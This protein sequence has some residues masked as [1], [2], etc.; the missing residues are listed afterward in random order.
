MQLKAGSLA[1]LT[2]KKGTVL[3]LQRYLGMGQTFACVMGAPLVW[4][5]SIT[6]SYA[7]RL[8]DTLLSTFTL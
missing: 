1:R 5:T 2:K 6:A 4:A 7:I 8:S 3:H